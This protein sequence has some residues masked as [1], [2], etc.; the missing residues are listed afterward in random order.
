MQFD[1]DDF[2]SFRRVIPADRWCIKCL[3]V[4]GP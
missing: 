4:D 1:A 2:D 3:R